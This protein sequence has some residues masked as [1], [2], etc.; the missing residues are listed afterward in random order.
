MGK[1]NRE[2][3]QSAHPHNSYFFT[4][5]GVPVMQRRVRGDAR[6]QQRRGNIQSEA[7]R[8]ADDEAFRD[9][10]F[11][12]VS[13]VGRVAVVIQGVIR[14]DNAFCAILFF[15]AEAV[16]A[17]AAG[18]N[19]AA[20]TDAVTDCKLGHF[21]TDCRHDAGDFVARHHREDPAAPFIKCTVKVGV[22]DAAVLNV[23]ENIVRTQFP[24]LDG[25]PLNGELSWE[26]LST[27]VVVV[28]FEA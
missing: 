9:D 26:A 17:L 25:G 15:P 7:V 28:C 23:D 12:A 27:R 1:L 11:L 13:A 14:G 20:N 5:A 18:I 8:N 3:S 2:V 22:A 6:T 19:K 21:R 10:D 24:P 4:G 16:F